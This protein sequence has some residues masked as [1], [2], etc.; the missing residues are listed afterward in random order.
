[1]A[2]GY[3]PNGLNKQTP[4]TN[5]NA[6]GDVLND[7]VIQ[8]VD[9]FVAG[10][11]SF[12]LS[13]TKTLTSTNGVSNEA[14]MAILHITSGTGGA[15][16]IPARSKLYM[17]FNEASGDVRLAPSG[18]TAA[19]VETTE[20]TL[21]FC[22]GTNAYSM[23]VAGDSWK[24]YVDAQAFAALAGDLPAQPG[25]SGKVLSTNGTVAGWSN[26][27]DLTNYTTDQA[28][29]QAAADKRAVGFA[30]FPRT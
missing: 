8:L 13:G 5:D 9:E 20:A 6:W 18:G 10:R 25:N 21:I 4:G 7:E 23:G 17:V 1:M 29:R 24:A 22:D 16:V 15:I 28:T 3:T 12:S 26:I 27:T 2:A 30:Y 11:A 19:T 14:R